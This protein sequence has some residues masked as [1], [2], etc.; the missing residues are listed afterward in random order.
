MKP[1]RRAPKPE[2][3][4]PENIRVTNGKLPE[5]SLWI[6][7]NDLPAASGKT[8]ELLN[9]ATAKTLSRV[10]EGGAEDVDRAVKAAKK[11]LDGPWSRFSS[12]E[13]ARVLFKF[14]GLIRERITEL[15]DMETT[16]TGKPVR[17]SYDEA[18]A[19]AN[20]IEYYAGAVSR[21]YGETIPVGKNGVN[22]TL[23]EPVGVCGLI[24]P[25]NYPAVIASWKLGPALA[26]GNTVVL[27]PSELTPLSAL[28][29]ARMAG[30]AGVPEGVINVVTGAGETAG[31]AL[32][33]HP[34]VAKI[35]FTGS[36]EIG[37]SIIR[38]SAAT[39]KRVSLELGGKSPNIVFDDADMPR[40]IEGSVA[41][42][43]SNT[44]QDCCARSR[45]IVHERVYDEFLEKVVKRTQK[46]V[47]GDPYNADT[48]LGPMITSG[49]RQ[50]TLDYIRAGQREGAKLLCGGSVP[51]GIRGFYV[52]P[53]V[54]S[55][56]DPGMPIAREEIF[57]P[58]L[59]V[60]SFKTE[61]E[62]VQLANA[63]EYGLSGSIWTRDS[64]R[65]LRMARAVRSGNLSVN[66]ASSVHLEAPFGGYKKSGVG[67]ELG[68]KAMDLYTEVKN[69]FI[70]AD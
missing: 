15:S 63:T 20:T 18:E 29:L 68:M 40:C 45:A 31:A 69:V 64:A 13:R 70:S 51:D 46:Y 7:G 22:M 14:A 37:Q 10:A 2:V 39:L 42:V 49:Q 66:C 61:E 28:W 60:L 21:H 25:W 6:D 33:E 23:R 50:R 53:A 43:F 65:A 19:V 55:Q 27:K 9:P 56:V 35:S 30:E 17:D 4:S 41:S 32:V 16:N 44:G 36:T 11:A 26:C 47:V 34:D 24:V 12:R 5:E 3:T 8:R 54:L 62:A 52:T 48:D 38:A 1:P 58:V 59:C 57:G 67:R